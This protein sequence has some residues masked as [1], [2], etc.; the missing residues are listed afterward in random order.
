M[1]FVYLPKMWRENCA[2][3]VC[4]F[5]PDYIKHFVPDKVYMYDNYISPQN[6]KDSMHSMES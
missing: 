4:S 2:N 3:E 1:C 6:K 5:I